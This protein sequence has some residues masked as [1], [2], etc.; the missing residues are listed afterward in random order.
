MLW[1]VAPPETQDQTTGLGKR[2]RVTK[3]SGLAD[4]EIVLNK[5]NLFGVGVSKT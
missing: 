5:H 2:N 4:I 3:R 1:H